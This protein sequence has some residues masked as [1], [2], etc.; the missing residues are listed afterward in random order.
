MN[1]KNFSGCSGIVLDWCRDHGSWFDRRELQ[2]IV[3]FIR[4]GGLRKAREREI[5]NIQDQQNRLR[6]Q[7]IELAVVGKKLD[8]GYGASFESQTESEPLM[9]FL[10]KNLLR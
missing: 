10:Y 5:Q 9:L 8:F 3:T 1:H 7:Q 6:M 4:N 2:Q